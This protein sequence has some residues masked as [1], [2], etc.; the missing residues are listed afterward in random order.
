MKL[1]KA[2]VD[3]EGDDGL[4]A[5]DTY[6]RR[7][8][9]LPDPEAQIARIGPDT[10]KALDAYVSG[11]NDWMAENGPVFEFKLPGY[12]HPEPYA[13]TDCLR[14]AKVFGFLGLADIQANMEKFLVQMIQK[15][16]SE[17]KLV[18]LFPCLTDPID[19]P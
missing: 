8:N 1:K 19:T 2:P 18:E 15:G 16:L 4:I 5:I 10:R 3:L 13:V 14:L 9:F 7:M 12:R 17:E 6:M 11:F